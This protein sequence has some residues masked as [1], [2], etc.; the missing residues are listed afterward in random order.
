MTGYYYGSLV[1]SV[2]QVVSA[3]GG[4][5]MLVATAAFSSG[6]HREMVIEELPH[7]GWHHAS[8]FLTI[9]NAV[10]LEFLEALREA[11][12][13]VVAL[14]HEEPGFTYPC[15]LPDNHGGTRRAVDHL[16]EHGH[17]RIAFAG[18]L[19]HFDVQERYAAY[20][21]ALLAHGIDPD[22]NLLYDIEDNN[23]FAGRRAGERMLAAGLP[24]S[25]VVAAVDLT[26]VG[27]ISVL[28]EAGLV[29]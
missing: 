3:A 26:A 29:L 12:K 1:S 18:S 16:V 23:E 11:G 25:A 15:V 4:R 22:P 6:Y 8:G 24:S 13:P 19:Q 5:V 10:S 27:I 21:N 20:R 2:N 17:T 28:R 9:A 14:G 7:L